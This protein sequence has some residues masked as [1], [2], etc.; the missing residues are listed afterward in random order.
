MDRRR[1]RPDLVEVDVLYRLP[2]GS[3]HRL[4]YR[5]YGD[6]AVQVMVDFEPGSEDLPELPRFG[7]TMAIPADFIEMEW[8]GRGPHESY[9]D[10]RSGAAVGRYRGTVRQQYHPYPRPQENGNK[11]DVR[12]ASWTAASGR[13]LLAVGL[14]LLSLSA[15]HYAQEDF[16]EG[17]AKRQ[18]HTIDLV[19]RDFITLNLDFK[20]M[21]VGGDTSWGAVA[22]PRYSLWPQPLDYSFLLR[23]FTS[24]DPSPA[25]LALAILAKPE[26]DD[27]DKRRTLEL[28]HFAE[29]NRVRHLAFD[30]PVTVAHPS[31]PRYSAGGDA[32]LTDG[33]RG[34][35][36]YRGGEWQAYEGVDFEA[37]VDLE[38]SERLGSIKTGFLHRPGSRILLPTEIEYALS[39]D[40][41]AFDVVAAYTARPDLDANGASRHYFEKTLD[42]RSA[43][44]VRVRAKNPGRSPS[45]PGDEGRPAIINVDEI[46]IR[47]ADDR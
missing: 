29:R 18:R 27:A 15:H 11:T 33:I 31:S 20:Q 10:R 32:A 42:G 5:I 39:E 35:I 1:L 12:W 6:G 40:G 14:P 7:T 38:S 2:K 22:H 45:T 30:R 17:E 13:G 34:S 44:Y 8:Y 24:A 3:S 23:P 47:S 21:G 46:I 36:A 28:D 43:R 41:G 25:D 16:D 9:W 4:T 37:V 19:E 26:I